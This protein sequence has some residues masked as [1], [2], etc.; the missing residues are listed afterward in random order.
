M[1]TSSASFTVMTTNRWPS[2]APCGGPSLLTWWPSSPRVVS[3]S[4]S[5]GGPILPVWWPSP[6]HVVAQPSSRG[7]QSFFACLRL[8]LIHL[9]LY[10]DKVTGFHLYPNF[11]SQIK[12]YGHRDQIWPTSPWSLL[13]EKAATCVRSNC[14]QRPPD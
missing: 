4:S 8:F 7:E 1:H 9:Y 12:S 14:L 13:H 5:R 11:S 6:L 2:S 3:Q 10:V